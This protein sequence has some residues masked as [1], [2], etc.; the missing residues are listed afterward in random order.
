[1]QPLDGAKLDSA[2]IEELVMSFL[3]DD[4][5]EQLLAEKELDCSYAI[6]GAR[7]RVNIFYQRNAMAAAFRAIPSEIP[8]L[9]NIGFGDF[10]GFLDM[11]QKGL[12]IVTGAT[13]TGKST[14]LAACV[15]YLNQTRQSHILTMEDPIEFVHHH[16]KCMVNQREILSDSL[17]FK[18]AL[19]HSLRQDPDIILVGEMRDLETMSAAITM[20]ETG[21]IVFTTLHTIDAA[22]TVDRIID[23][24]PPY[25]QQQIRMQLS[26]ALKA[27]V[28]QQLIPKADGKGRVAAREI[29]FSTPAIS[30]LIREGKTHQI[31][32][33]IQTGGQAGMVT[34]D[35]ALKKLYKEKVITY[36]EASSRASNPMAIPA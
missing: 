26:T 16:K 36:E 24:F 9:D 34:L 27:I 15:D 17:S 14:T 29:M 5:K 20:A 3:K 19:K 18:E 8:S 10:K 32:S 11:T 13:G 22:Q 25:Q 33:A 2:T 30:N 35:N 12:I 1:L 21:H 7:F 6:E 28:S 23:V 4:Q 31:Y